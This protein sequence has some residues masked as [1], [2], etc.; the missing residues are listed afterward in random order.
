MQPTLALFRGRP[1]LGVGALSAHDVRGTAAAGPRNKV[2]DYD[3]QL[4]T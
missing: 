4:W 2:I 1:D 3:K